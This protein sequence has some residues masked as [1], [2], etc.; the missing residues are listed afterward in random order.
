M[1]HIYFGFALKLAVIDAHHNMD[2]DSMLTYFPYSVISSGIS[3]LTLAFVYLFDSR[4]RKNV[5]P[6]V[7]PDYIPA[8]VLL[9]SFEF[10]AGFIFI[11]SPEFS[12][13]IS[14]RSREAFRRS[15]V[16]IFPV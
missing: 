4:K 8:V 5:N 10:Y 9:R 3:N 1:F 13:F 15:R 16:P 14:D 2:Y 12:Q 7:F 11:L 6:F